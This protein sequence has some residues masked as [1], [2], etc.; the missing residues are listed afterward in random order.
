M[1]DQGCIDE[2]LGDKARAYGCR[3][4][5]P[6]HTPPLSPEEKANLESSALQA[7][8]QPE[9]SEPAKPERPNGKMAAAHDT[10]DE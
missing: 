4:P 8:V 6:L 2:L 7:E 3:C 9:Q 10:D 5:C 1:S